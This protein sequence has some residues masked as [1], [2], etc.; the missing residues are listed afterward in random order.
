MPRKALYGERFRLRQTACPNAAGLEWYL[1]ALFVNFAPEATEWNVR[2]GMVI[3]EANLCRMTVGI[4]RKRSGVDRNKS[5][6]A[7]VRKLP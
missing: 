4:D 1:C 5:E 3:Y 2:V 6:I 7:V